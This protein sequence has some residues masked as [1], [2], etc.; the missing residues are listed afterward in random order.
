MQ[1]ARF[2]FYGSLNDFL[3][4]RNKDSWI[5]YP[6]TNTPAIK[7]AIEAI[8]IPHTEVNEI[9]INKQPVP[10]YHPLLPD[11]VAEV[12]P[13]HQI[14][15]T[16]Q[17]FILDVH[18][19]KLA[20][21]LRLLGFDTLYESTYTDRMIADF[22]KVE[23]RIVLTRDINLLKQKVIEWG[24]WLRS[25]HPSQ[26]LQEV[27]HRYL[28]VDKIRPFTRCLACN[29]C[30][31]SVNKE[32]IADRLPPDTARYFHE[33]YQC[34]SCQRVY[35]KGSHYDRMFQWIEKIKTA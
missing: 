6:F 25:Q 1:T 20:R 22:I 29:G 33:F 30:I 18:L 26:Q 21:L 23:N 19:G 15:S 17:K 24:Y 5:T 10:F 34:R 3:R 11:T 13:Y 4:P 14:S 32:E 27:L 28:L 2:R 8:G 7:D 35:W 31:D 12:Y 9:L 16:P